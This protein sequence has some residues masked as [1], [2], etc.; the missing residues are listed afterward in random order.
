MFRK[1]AP[2]LTLTLAALLLTACAGESDTQLIASAQQLLAKKDN[3]GAVIQLKTALQ[4]NPDSAEARLLLGKTLL[5]QGDPVTA[6]VELRKAQELRVPDE[7]VVPDMARAML[8]V[9]DGDKLIAQFGALKLTDPVAAADLRTTVATALGIQNNLDGARAAIAEA[10]RL[11][12]GYG[13]ALLIQA[14]LE[15][16]GGK[17]DEAL[18][19]LDQSLAADPASERTGVFK[20]ELLLQ[21]KQDPE[22]AKAAFR[23]VLKSTP[24]SVAARA[25]VANILFQQQKLEDSRAEFVLLKKSAPNHPETLF[26]E[27]QLAFADKDYKKTRETAELILKNFPD[28]VRV[29]ELGGAAE[30][31]LRN[32]VQAEGLLGRALKLA[33]RQLLTRQ[34]LA[35]TYLRSGQADKAVQVLQP[36]LEGGKPDAGSLSLAGEAYLQIGDEKRSEQAFQM[37]LKI[38]PNDSQVRTTAAIAQIARGNAT[39]AETALAQVVAGDSSPRA[40]LALVSA[41]LRNKDLPGAL[42]AIDGLAKKLPDSPLPSQLRGRVFL[43]QQNNAG[44]AAQFEAALAKDTNYFPAVASLAALDY[45]QGKSDSA[46]QRFQ[47][48]LKTQP[49]SWQAQLALA[50]LEARTGAPPTKVT[51]SVRAAVKLNPSEPRPHLVLINNLL[52]VGDDKAA[53]QAAQDAAAALPNN[54]DIMDAQGRA[55]TA[56][57][58]KQRAVTT[59]KKL[60][61]LQPR[62]PQHPM[63]LADAYLALKDYGAAE[64]ALRQAIELAP[65]ALAPRRALA[66]VAL[67]DKRPKD[68][69]AVAREL[70]KRE[71]K[72]AVGYTLEGEIEASAKNWDAAIAAFRAAQ[73]RSTDADAVAKLHAALNASGKTEEADRLG[74]DWVKSHPKE[75]AFT[76]YLG[77]MALARNDLVGAEA[78]YRQVLAVQPDNALALNNVAWLLAKQG[79]PGALPMAE[80]AVSLLPDRAPLL[81]TLS[82][83]LEAENQVPRAIEVQK[84]AISL[85]PGDPR[86]SMRLAKLY[87][88]SG[89]KDRARAELEALAKLG[90]KFGE[91]AEVSTLMKT[92]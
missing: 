74:A 52:A 53:L 87:I 63:R 81:D 70:Q 37:A 86:L 9:G 13:P 36:V 43:L 12:P 33:P 8:A 72:N 31:R 77:D 67:A 80:K 39:G 17:V 85:A 71:P 92:L 76:Y 22:A 3:K 27:A 58:D 82:T 64:R 60:A 48:Y 20:G 15:A 35:Q 55:E 91:Q 24:D 78:R 66:A 41:R 56:A 14:R 88:K 50:E 40:D 1:S 29:L 69:V 23:A 57:G 42:K 10:L 18:T 11:K 4:K 84:R 79:K 30:F 26:L 62:N 68:A 65:E 28:S 61:S 46:R 45:T 49:K 89:D 16:A 25:A 19:L 7:R 5:E 44:A 90:A 34:L 75:T 2:A 38:A 59:F 54:F 83:V 51:E 47:N 32:Y 73:Q 21:S 6:L